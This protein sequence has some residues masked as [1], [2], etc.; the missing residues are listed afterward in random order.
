MKVKGFSLKGTAGGDYLYGGWNDDYVVGNAGDDWLYGWGGNNTLLGGAGIDHIYA[1]DGNNFASGGSGDDWFVLGS[2]NNTVYGGSG[3]DEIYLGFREELYTYY[4]PY[5]GSYYSYTIISPTLTGGDNFVDAGAGDDYVNDNSGDSVVLLG[6]GNDFAWLG[7]GNDYARGGDG[8]DTLYSGTGN[9]TLN[10]GAGFD[11]LRLNGGDTG[12]VDGLDIVGFEAVEG[13]HV[14]IFG[15]T[16]DTGFDFTNMQ[17]SENGNG[18]YTYGVTPEQLSFDNAGNLHVVVPNT[19]F[20]IGGLP[21]ASVESMLASN[22]VVL[23]T[24]Y[25]YDG[26]G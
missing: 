12:I 15:A 19:E 22:N 7:G 17:F 18:T 24:T 11:Y 16:P 10:G 6:L 5:T 13:G 20:V 23:S 4:D 9:D 8:N 3:R 1:E 21:Y 25:S 26:K 2:G 14:N